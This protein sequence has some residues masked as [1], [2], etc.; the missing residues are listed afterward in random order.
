MFGF[1]GIFADRRPGLV[2]ALAAA[3]PLADILSNTPPFDGIGLRFRPDS[4]DREEE[5]I[6]EDVRSTI[7]QLSSAFP[8]ARFVVLRTLCVGADCV[9]WGLGFAHGSI[10]IDTTEGAYDAK[11]EPGSPDRTLPRLMRFLGLELDS[12]EYFDPLRRDYPWRAQVER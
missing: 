3:W 6:A 10:V 4:Y 2:Q 1:F 5:D 12:R 7:K 8:D 9:N 11:R